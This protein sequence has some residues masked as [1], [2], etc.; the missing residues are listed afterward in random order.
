MITKLYRGVIKFIKENYAILLFAI[1]IYILFTI[2]LPWSIYAP[3]G[4]IPIEE[5]LSGDVIKGKGSLNLTYVTFIDGTIPSLLLAKIFPHWDIVANKDITLEKENMQDVLKRDLIYLDESISNAL[6]VAYTK[7]N[8]EITIMNTKYYILYI[9]DEA[10]TSLKV[11]DEILSFDG[12]EF[13]GIAELNSYIGTLEVGTTIKF[14]VLRNGNMRT[15]DAEI[16]EINGAQ[17]IGI[18][19]S[20]INEYAKD[21]NVDYRPKE[22]ESGPSGGLMIA[23]AIYN[24]LVDEDI[25]QGLKISGTGTID[26]D[27]NVG[28][29]GGVK[30]KLR[31]AV[32][33]KS[34]VF[35]VPHD[36]YEEAK[37]EKDANGYDIPIIEAFTF[38]QVLEELKNIAQ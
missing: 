2:H 23:L 25:T 31:G 29:I 22:D 16:V 35:I 37:K 20:S 4:A 11:G 8:K 28:S 18:S 26:L 7:A 19:I 13:T 6:N 21:P 36:N 5:R 33:E 1:I 10:K 38:D 34:D 14:D 30:Y 9:V 27:G 32:S 12:H 15:C 24:A 3:G 17:K